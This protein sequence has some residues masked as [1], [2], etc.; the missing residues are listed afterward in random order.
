MPFDRLQLSS[1][2]TI[3]GCPPRVSGPPNCLHAVK[4]WLKQE[5]ACAPKLDLR[6]PS[7]DASLQPWCAPGCLAY[8]DQGWQQAGWQGWEAGWN[9][10]HCKG[11]CFLAKRVSSACRPCMGSLFQAL[12]AKRL[13]A[14]LWHLTTILW[15]SAHLQCLQAVQKHLT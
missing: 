5:A 14:T 8:Q 1:A 15:P 3:M 4:H 2:T 12:A 6:L 9:Q 11:F 7:L 10:S 13:L